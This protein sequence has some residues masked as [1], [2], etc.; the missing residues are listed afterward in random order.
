MSKTT[1][2]I[3]TIV[4]CLIF[5]AN[6]TADLLIDIAVESVQHTEPKI[7]QSQLQLR[8]GKDYL[9]IVESDLELIYDFDT[10]RMLW[11]NRTEHYYSDT[12]LYA[13]VGGWEHEPA[14]YSLQGLSQ[15]YDVNPMLHKLAGKFTGDS[16]SARVAN[17]NALLVTARDALTESRFLESMLDYF[18][19]SLVSGA[20]SLPWSESE[21]A[22]IA[23]DPQVKQLFAAIQNPK[24]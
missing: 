13:A 5:A 24:N 9:K 20:Q 16:Q 3:G 2:A 12:S 19:Y 23:A 11:I 4:C 14:V 21:R 17:E 22:T 6:C 10:R 18:E 7:K 8:L 15:R 1:I